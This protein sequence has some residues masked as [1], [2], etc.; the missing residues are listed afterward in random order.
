MYM[1]TGL[2]NFYEICVLFDNTI[3]KGMM[4]CDGTWGK[5]KISAQGKAPHTVRTYGHTSK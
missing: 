5:N 1:S 4:I 3:W 2:C